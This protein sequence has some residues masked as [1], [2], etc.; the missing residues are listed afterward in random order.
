[1]KVDIIAIQGEATE[2]PRSSS[3]RYFLALDTSL[4]DLELIPFTSRNL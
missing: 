4:L 3:T 2:H 1:M